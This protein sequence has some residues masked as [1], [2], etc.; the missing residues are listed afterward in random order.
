V[1]KL[2]ASGLPES[3][4]LGVA[5]MP[6]LTAYAGLLRIAEF[7]PSDTVFVSGAAGAVGSTVVHIAKIKGATVIGSAGGAQKC[8]L[9]KS[10]G[11]DHVIDYKQAKGFEGLVAALKTAAPKG[12][13][14]YFDNVG[15]DHL[16][17]AIE[18]ARPLA[19]FA[20]CGM[21]AQ[22][23]ETG[24]PEGP[25]NIIMAVGKQLTLRGFI[26]SSHADLQPQFLADMAKWIASGQM[27]FEET[28]MTGI[29][30]APEAFLGLFTGANT[31][32]MLVKLA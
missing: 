2:P 32:K 10:L 24:K 20:L 9:V 7:K 15:G 12:I 8:A 19:R 22:Y 30:K 3:A 4:F 21:I 11:A 1:Q 28:V 5:G 17:A 23:N 27:K 18:A 31:G 16:A 6:G 29:E 26:V 14:I 25:H 13:D